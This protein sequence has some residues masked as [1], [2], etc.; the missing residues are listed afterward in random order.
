MEAAGEH[1]GAAERKSQGERS[2]RSDEG[3]PSQEEE[4]QG[5]KKWEMLK[6]R[7][8]GQTRDE[9]CQLPIG[10]QQIS[11]LHLVV[12]AHRACDFSLLEFLKGIRK[13]RSRN[14]VTL[15][16]SYGRH[17]RTLCAKLSRRSHAQTATISLKSEK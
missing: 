13:S 17:A 15:E 1:S 6:Q 16:R 9:T 10:K 8:G 5:R 12:L 2:K 14:E 11:Q 4:G 3:V 7:G